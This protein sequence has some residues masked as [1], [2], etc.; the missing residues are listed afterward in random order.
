MRRTLE[1]TSDPRL[2]LLLSTAFCHIGALKMMDDAER[3]TCLFNRM[4]LDKTKLRKKKQVSHWRSVT[5]VQRASFVQHV[6]PHLQCLPGG[7]LK[8]FA[9]KILPTFYTLPETEHLVTDNI[10]GYIP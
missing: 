3:R 9:G 1:Q 4:L 6:E 8:C 2:E 10:F 5:E 7:G